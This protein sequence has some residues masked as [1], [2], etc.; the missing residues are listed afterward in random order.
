MP[1]NRLIALTRQRLARAVVGILVLA[2]VAFAQ[3]KLA[4]VPRAVDVATINELSPALIKD[5]EEF[6]IEAPTIN[7]AEGM[8]FSHDGKTNEIVDV[9]FDQA[10]LDAATVAT[11]ESY[12]FGLKPPATPARIYYQAQESPPSTEQPCHTQV[13]LR[14]TSQ[15][16]AEIRLSQFDPPGSKLDRYLQVKFKGAELTT[17][18]IT[19]SADDSDRGPGC[20]K[21]L[22]VGDWKQSFASGSATIVAAQDSPVRFYFRPRTAD[23]NLWAETQGFLPLAL[24][25]RKENSTQPV[26]QARE[27][28]INLVGSDGSSVARVSARSADGGPLLTING[29][30]LG[31]D[32]MRISIAGKGFVKVNGK[33]ATVNLLKPIQDNPIL[34]ALLVATNGALLAWV[35][36]LVF[37]T[38]QNSASPKD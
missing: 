24:G 34:L 4:H 23:E 35:A 20:Q 36:R 13:E 19:D 21:L 10:R 1:F 30:S 11:F 27:V 37:K 15:M 6:V 22:R 7:A 28:S 33:P 18:V 25:A 12:G 17:N 16:P 14:T 8:L 26:F 29:L 9:S 3:Y 31:P 32:Q 2:G 5:G 38:P